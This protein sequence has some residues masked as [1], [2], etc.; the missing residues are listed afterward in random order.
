MPMVGKVESFTIEASV[1][2]WR[3]VSSVLI[4]A[5]QNRKLGDLESKRAHELLDCIE[6]NTRNMVPGSILSNLHRFGDEAA[7]QTQTADMV[8][9]KS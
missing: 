7:G 6:S 1:P 4:K 5:I 3:S 9:R 2:E 8:N